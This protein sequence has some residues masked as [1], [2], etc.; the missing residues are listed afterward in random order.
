MPPRRTGVCRGAYSYIIYAMNAGTGENDREKALLSFYALAA[1]N[2]FILGLALLRDWDITE[3]FVLYWAESGIIAGFAVLK[4]LF[5]GRGGARGLPE[6][7]LKF[8]LSKLLA[9]PL[10]AFMYAMAMT[11]VWLFMSVILSV[12][13]KTEIGA[14]PD[15]APLRAGLLALAAGHAFGFLK[16][17]L[18]GGA[19]R[20]AD[21]RDLVIGPAAGLATLYFALLVGTAVM[22]MGVFGDSAVLIAAFV[23]VKTALD[24]RVLVKGSW[25]RICRRVTGLY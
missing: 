16:D 24:L 11:V 7:A 23:A 25:P 17:Y 10:T 14:P 20:N 13:A 9:A 4:I 6:G 1:S 8:H 15:L 22:S 3:I 21:L 19:S 18:F 12:A 2:L 5:A